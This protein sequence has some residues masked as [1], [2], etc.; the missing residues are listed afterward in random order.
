MG[1][2]WDPVDIY[3]GN[4]TGRDQ[5][6]RIPMG[7]GRDGTMYHGNGTGRDWV[8]WEWDGMGPGVMGMGMGMNKFWKSTNSHLHLL[9]TYL[10]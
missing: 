9:F 10:N 1:R 4:G 8:P 7:M 6:S 2:E 5:I 3:Y